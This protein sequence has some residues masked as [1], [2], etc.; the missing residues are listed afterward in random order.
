MTRLRGIIAPFLLLLLIS[1]AAFAQSVRGKVVDPDKRPVADAKVLILHG[2]AVVAS[3][4]TESDGEYGPVPVSA[5]YYEVTAAAPG[6][7]TP[8]KSVSVKPRANGREPRALALSAV[9][10]RRR[11]GRRG[12]VPLSR[13]TESVT[14]KARGL[15]PRRRTA[16]RTLRRQFQGNPAA[17]AR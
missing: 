14:V 13:T 12:E 6:L 4:T 11:L 1:T 10:I 9:E 3:A 8:A 17:S 16:L 5:G 7:G 15:D 2:D